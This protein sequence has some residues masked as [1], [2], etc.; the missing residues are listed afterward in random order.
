MNGFIR[1]TS[2]YTTDIIDF[3]ICFYATQKYMIILS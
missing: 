1:I 3:Q 2:K